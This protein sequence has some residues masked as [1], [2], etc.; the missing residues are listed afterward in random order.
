MVPKQGHVVVVHHALTC[1]WCENRAHYDFK[2]YIG[3]WAYACSEHWEKYR[4]YPETGLG[5]G[6]RL[7]LP[8]EVTTEETVR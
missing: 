5:M 4:L 6:Q 8:S 1:N 7:I 3:P 2:T